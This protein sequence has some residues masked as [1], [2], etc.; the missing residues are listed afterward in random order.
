MQGPWGLRQMAGARQRPETASDDGFTTEQL[1]QSEVLSRGGLPFG[2]PH[3]KLSPI[4][5]SGCCLRH[6]RKQCLA[7]LKAKVANP[8]QAG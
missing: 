5:V 8:Q 3:D 7:S 2:S 6:A 4:E 1:L